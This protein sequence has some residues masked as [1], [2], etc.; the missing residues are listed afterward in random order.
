MVGMPICS[1]VLRFTNYL[2]CLLVILSSE[3]SQNKFL[4][5]IVAYDIV[6]LKKTEE[7]ASFVL[8][9]MYRKDVKNRDDKIVPFLIFGSQS[10]P[11]S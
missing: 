7:V 11:C 10:E 2:F 6:Q 8:S 5:D 1:S 9:S 3:I 4:V